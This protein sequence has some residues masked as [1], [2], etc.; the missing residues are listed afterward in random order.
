MRKI[1]QRE[2]L[3]YQRVSE[4][5]SVSTHA[6][7]KWLSHGD[8]SEAQARELAGKI[9]F[10]WLWLKYGIHRVPLD[11]F[12]DMVMASANNMLLVRWTDF[13]AIAASEDKLNQFE[14]DREDLIGR[15]FM[16]FLTDF[17]E[18]QGRYIQ[19]VV[20]A[21]NGMVEHSFRCTCQDKYSTKALKINCKGITTDNEGHTYEIAQ[22]EIVEPNGT[23]GSLR[24]L[25]LHR[26][27][28]FCMPEQDICRLADQYIELPW[29]AD[30]LRG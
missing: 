17:T 20:Y 11:T 15:S 18:E 12:H 6:V 1:M 30:F 10:D 23:E 2:G 7:Y 24:S 28:P 4:Y 26:K 25:R 5:A 9:G 22:I 16:E 27:N 21:L 14:Y 19:R 3:T 13:K 8:I 29:L